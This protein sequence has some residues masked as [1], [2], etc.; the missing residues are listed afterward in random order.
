MN[1]RKRI[2]LVDDEPSLLSIVRRVVAREHPQMVTVYASSP[3]TAEWQL[4][5]TSIGL[6][7]T[8]MRMN[9]D[10]LAGLRVVRAARQ[11]G[12]PVAL[13]TGGGKPEHEELEDVPFI[14]KSTMT[15]QRLSQVIE[16][17]FRS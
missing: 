12:V 10:E 5:S 13:L 17:A 7:V 14:D 11:A 1:S 9:A 16:H 3:E 8:D 6:V 4:N 15:T 2:L